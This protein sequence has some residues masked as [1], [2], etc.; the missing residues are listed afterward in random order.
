MRN[1]S[2]ALTTEQIRAGTKTVTRRWG[3]K[4][5]KP[6]DVI[7]PVRKAM[8]LRA[9]EK[10]EPL[11]AP[12]RVT[13]VRFEPLRR[14]T[15][16]VEYGIEECRR[17]GF[18]DHPSYCWPSEFVKFFCDT[19]GCGPGTLVTRIEFEYLPDSIE[20]DHG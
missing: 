3:W 14:M 19:H 1:M 2:F 13:D 8:G 5:L 18:G 11:R 12:I 15:D 9:G 10:I 6:G 20:R 17:E 4:F 7:R 16:D